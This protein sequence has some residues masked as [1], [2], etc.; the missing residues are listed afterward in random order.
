L[1]EN[2]G[3]TPNDDRREYQRF[4]VDFP[5]TFTG[6]QDTGKGTVTTLSVRG[7][8]IETE[9]RL[10]HGAGVSLS[11]HLPG[12]HSPI[13]VEKA[14]VRA[15]LGTRFGLEFV[16]IDPLDDEQLRS[17]IEMLIVTGPGELRK[18]FLNR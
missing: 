4:A 16:E 2:Y 14:V 5:A 1:G 10:H 18:M 7:C 9:T 15:A 13:E 17:H 6:E 11:L 3:P 8:C 12:F